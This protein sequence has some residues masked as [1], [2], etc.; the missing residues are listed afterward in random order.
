[1][2]KKTWKQ[3]ANSFK[4]ER[5]ELMDSLLAKY[6]HNMRLFTEDDK[7]QLKH[8]FNQEEACLANDKHERKTKAMKRQTFVHIWER[9]NA[10][11]MEAGKN[12][13][14]TPMT[15]VSGVPGGEQRADYIS[16][17]P[18]GFAWV[19]MKPGTNRFAKW[20]VDMEIASKDS[21][22]GGVTIWCSGF[23]QSIARKTA[24]AEAVAKSLREYEAQRYIESDR[25]YAQSRLD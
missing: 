4:K 23:G 12:A 9:A 25:I 11:G 7:A 18:C 17:G 6:D 3:T 2:R 14:P 5:S 24:W 16:E 22:Y 10:A 1:M 8:L 13:I 20:L 19:N 15:V 21:Y